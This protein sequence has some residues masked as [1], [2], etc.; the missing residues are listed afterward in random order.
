MYE[1]A[2]NYVSGASLLHRLDPRVKL[3]GVMLFSILLFREESLIGMGGFAA[4]FFL[5][6]LSSKLRI[7]LLLRS[8]RPL[9]IFIIFIFCIQLF[10]TEGSPLFSVSS[11]HPTLEG[12][13]LGSL[14]ALRFSL[15]LLYTALLTASTPPGQITNGI[16]RLL[17][18]LPLNFLGVSSFDLASMMSL[19]IRFL[20][21]FLEN[22]ASI[23]EAQ[24]ARGLDFR[25]G[26]FR[27]TAAL[28]VPLIKKSL[29]SAE[30]V[31]LAMES[32]CYQGTYRTSLHELKFM[33][34]DWVSLFALAGFFTL[35]FLA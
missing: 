2:F 8:V 10:M 4:L 33:R 34:A 20:P 5:L 32:R 28:A 14:L 1:T 15:L 12:L 35:A 21:T 17:R 31:A 11:F 24:L 18:P 13:K 6:A 27:G 19:S 26:F 3:A 16:E 7:R 30:E 25:H 29:R 22:A 9:A 23:R